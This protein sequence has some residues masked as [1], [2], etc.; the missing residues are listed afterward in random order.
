MVTLPGIVV[1]SVIL[2][3]GWKRFHAEVTKHVQLAHWPARTRHASVNMTMAFAIISLSAVNIGLVMRRQELEEGRA[4]LGYREHLLGVLLGCVEVPP[5]QRQAGQRAQMVDGEEMPAQPSRCA[6][7]SA[8][9]AASLDSR[10][11]GS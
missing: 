10:G 6:S 1:A 11:I 9:L 2:D 4:P 8:A 5:L 3:F 7:A